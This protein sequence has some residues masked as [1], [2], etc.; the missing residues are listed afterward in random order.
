MK[1]SVKA[2]V[3]V[4]LAILFAAP[5]L[6]FAAESLDKLSARMKVGAMGKSIKTGDL[7]G[8]TSL[9]AVR[10][11]DGLT[12]FLKRYD[13]Y[14]HPNNS[15]VDCGDGL[16]MT[17]AGIKPGCVVSIKLARKQADGS[18]RDIGIRI[19]YGVWPGAR[20]FSANSS[21]AKSAIQGDG[22][23]ELQMH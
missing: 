19:E 4:S 7:N 2:V 10:Y 17:P 8:F 18:F 6:T 3:A 15:F 14:P 5:T 21:Y 9:P 13:V 22:L 12:G 1:G 16:V 11:P 23:L 20:S